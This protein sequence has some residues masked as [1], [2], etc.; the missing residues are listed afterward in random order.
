MGQQAPFIQSGRLF[1]FIHRRRRLHHSSPGGLPG[2]QVLADR[3]RKHF[4]LL[5]GLDIL[6]R[7]RRRPH[8]PKLETAPHYSAAVRNGLDT[9]VGQL[10]DLGGDNALVKENDPAVGGNDHPGIERPTAVPP[11]MGLSGIRL[12][13]TAAQTLQMLVA[14]QQTV[15]HFPLAGVHIGVGKGTPTFRNQGIP[16]LVD[17]LLFANHRR[18]PNLGDGNER[19]GRF[20]K[21]LGIL[22]RKDVL[23]PETALGLGGHGY[24]PIQHSSVEVESGNVPVVDF[25]DFIRPPAF[26]QGQETPVGSDDQIGIVGNRLFGAEVAADQGGQTLA[27]VQ[28]IAEHSPLVGVFLDAPI[29]GGQGVPICL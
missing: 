17:A 3:I 19:L 1:Q 6:Q 22:F 15:K 8:Q 4:S 20:S 27:V 28:Q 23:H 18:H 14:F 21:H 12:E 7:E 13:I 11:D 10:G 25:G 26:T 29:S 9:F 5:L 24:T 2:I 16:F